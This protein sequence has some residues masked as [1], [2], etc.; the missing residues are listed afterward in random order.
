ML[1]E[2]RKV[3]VYINKDK[4]NIYGDLLMRSYGRSRLYRILVLI[5]ST[6]GFLI[7]LPG[8]NTNSGELYVSGKLEDGEGVALTF[9]YRITPHLVRKC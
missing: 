4:L 9:T 5:L 8:D 1:M 2:K 7:T 3:R 6:N